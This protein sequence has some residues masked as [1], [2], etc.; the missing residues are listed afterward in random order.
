MAFPVRARL[1]GLEFKVKCFEAGQH[2]EESD[3][4]S[5][6]VKCT[7]NEEYDKGQVRV[8]TTR[9]V[10]DNTSFDNPGNGNPNKVK[11][12]RRGADPPKNESGMTGGVSLCD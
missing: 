8:C 7:R 4:A 1:R 11:F 6:Q 10:A 9:W 3:H 12:R 5:P 2:G